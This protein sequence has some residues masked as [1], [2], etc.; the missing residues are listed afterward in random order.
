MNDEYINFLVTAAT[1]VF[2][3]VDFWKLGK[4]INLPITSGSKEKHEEPLNELIILYIYIFTLTA[5]KKGREEREDRIGSCKLEELKNK[6]AIDM[7]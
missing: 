3:T 1:A 7:R 2:H 6:Y 4:K 5:H